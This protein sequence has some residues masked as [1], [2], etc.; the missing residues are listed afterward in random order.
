MRRPGVEQLLLIA[1]LAIPN[2]AAGQT[3]PRLSEP[4]RVRLAEAFRV[5]DRVRAGVW[6][7]WERTPMAVLFVA[8]SFE[9][10]IGHP[11]PTGDFEALGHD[12]AL[13]RGVL[14]RPRRFPPALLATFPAVGGIST[15]VVG[16]SERTG[17]SS[18]E[19]LLT[20]L[21]EHFHQWQS[22]LPEYYAR[23]DALGL[24]RG[25]T[26]GQWMLNYPFP[27]DSAP[28]Q[29]AAEALAASLA[30]GETPDA[31]TRLRQAL[32]R[33]LSP[34][35][36]RYLEFQLWQEG[37]PRYLEIAV[38]EAAAR[39]GEPSQASRRLPD[40]EGYADLAF[41]LRNELDRRLEDLSLGRE[42]RIAFYALGAGMA[43]LLDGNDEGWKRR[44]REN[45]FTLLP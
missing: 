35:D 6:P 2:L 15:I 30:R 45:L 1:S 31:V 10:L 17:K 27:Y 11:R 34:D 9:Y 38:A 14:A 5:A 28:V 16:S 3:L 21:H 29:R 39:A 4:D 33:T 42:R 13:E 19:W 40:Y 8:D 20:L 7:G 23:A 37:V 24:A 26:T 41:R 44:Y 43:R 22:S 32:R 36:D 18:G 12:P 25:D